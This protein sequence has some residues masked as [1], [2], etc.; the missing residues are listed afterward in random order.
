MDKL[1]SVGDADLQSMVYKRYLKFLYKQQDYVSCM[2]HAC[3]MTESHPRDV[4]AYEWICMMHCENHEKVNNKAWQSELR[5]PVSDYAAQL[6]QLNPK[7]NL[8]LL[9]QA[10]ELYLKEQFVAARQ[11]ALQALEYQP[12]YRMTQQLL[13]RIHMK[14]GAHKLALLLWQELGEQ[15]EEYAQCLSYKMDAKLLEEASKLL[16]DK[17]ATDELSLKALARFVEYLYRIVYDMIG[18]LYLSILFLPS[19]AITNWEKWKS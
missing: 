5:R 19:G 8:A 12:S 17:A 1:L 11:L 6:L 4:Y 16:K 14:L 2:R 10:L 9:V 13:A 18:S 7:S 3:N 15:H